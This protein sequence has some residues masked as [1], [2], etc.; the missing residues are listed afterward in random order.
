[1]LSLI[2]GVIK[3]FGIKQVLTVIFGES[4]TYLV[5]TNFFLTKNVIML[6]EVYSVKNPFIVLYFIEKVV[7]NF[8]ACVLAISIS[9]FL[10]KCK[11][12]FSHVLGKETLG[13]YMLQTFVFEN[14]VNILDVSDKWPQVIRYGYVFAI[15]SIVTVVC[16]II[17]RLIRKCN[18]LATI[19]LGSYSKN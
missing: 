18:F 1:M 2:K 3:G 9:L 17:V 13:I 8:V 4:I 16:Y 11:Y 15:A 12:D 19:L 6:W 7:W 5:I 14:M 10:D